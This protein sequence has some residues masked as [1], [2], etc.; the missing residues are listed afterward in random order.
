MS[1]RERVLEQTRDQRG[2][3]RQGGDHQ[4]DGRKQL[5]RQRQEVHIGLRHR[6]RGIGHAHIH[7]Q[8]AQDHRQHHHEAKQEALA[9]KAR[10][11]VP[12][13]PHPA[14]API[15]CVPQMRT[16]LLSFY[17]SFRNPRL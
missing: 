7:Q 4:A 15:G 1:R 14:A 16:C 3:E 5:Q 11:P 12:F 17:L 8:Q 2:H 13:Q 10:K 9:Q 6:T